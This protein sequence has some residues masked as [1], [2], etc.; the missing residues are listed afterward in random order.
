[1]IVEERLLAPAKVNLYL[2]IVGRRPDG[3]HL[4][5]SLIA[6]IELCDTVRVRVDPTAPETT[7][8]VTS[9]SKAAPGGPQNLAY[10]AAQLFLTHTGR[11]AAVD[12]TINKRIPV[13]GGLGGGS[14]DAAAV[15]L[16][17]NRLL[18]SRLGRPELAQIGGAIGADVAF[19]VYGLPAHVRGVG[20]QVSA[21]R[22][23]SVPPLVVCWDRYLLST[24]LV[25]SRV[26]L[27]LTRQ[28]VTSNIT[29]FAS[30]GKPNPEMLVN[31][32]EEPAAQIHPE[33]LSLKSRLMA[34]GASGALM[35]GSGAAVFG[36]WTDMRS[37]Q[38]AATRLR[39][40]GL[41]AEA[42]R[43]LAVSPAAAR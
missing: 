35:T 33:V 22:L 7:I 9:D 28:P 30:S 15:L 5:D 10:R 27:S 26:M 1:M 6:P 21:V 2:R 13:G 19:F 41:W 11:A 40:S 37:A 34:E 43:V 39:R 18:G 17:L 8:L 3:Y 29:T 24:K 36:M 42:V 32:L 4:V 25:Y 31:D 12:V 16:A 14:S 38:G 23:P 20:D